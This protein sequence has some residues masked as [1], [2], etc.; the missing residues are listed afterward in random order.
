M[1]RPLGCSICWLTAAD[2]VI[3]YD[4]G[5]NPAVEDQAIN[6]AHRIGAAG[7]VTV[8]RMI[9]GGTI[10]QRID[11]VLAQKRELFATVFENESDSTPQSYGLTRS[12][13]LSLF[14]L[15]SPEGRLRDAA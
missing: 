7:P 11:E 2:T 8:T 4:P 6:R 14:D 1:P 12:E 15:R 9:A 10:E 13:L 3:H 5:W